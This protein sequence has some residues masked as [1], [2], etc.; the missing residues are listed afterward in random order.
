VCFGNVLL[1]IVLFTVLYE[2]APA[3]YF[4]S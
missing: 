1:F 4:L 2:C 3:S